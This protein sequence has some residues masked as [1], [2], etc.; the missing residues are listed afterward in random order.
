MY[1]ITDHKLNTHFYVDS[2]P[3]QIGDIPKS[4]EKKIVDKF[5]EF[6]CKYQNLIF[7]EPTFYCDS[8][9]VF[10]AQIFKLDKCAEL[11][12]QVLIDDEEF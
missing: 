3:L 8:H 10:R 1:L 11:F 2:H 5:E 9:V 6:K 12:R 4:I 7:G